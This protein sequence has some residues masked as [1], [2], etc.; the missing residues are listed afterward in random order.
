MGAEIKQKLAVGDLVTGDNVA[1]FVSLRLLVG[2]G[3]AN[4]D[5]VN[6]HP[7]KLVSSLILKGLKGLSSA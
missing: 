7:I 4:E 2:D 5:S 1:K 6:V 3:L